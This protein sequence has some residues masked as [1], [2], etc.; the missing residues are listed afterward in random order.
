MS[1]RVFIQLHAS[2]NSLPTESR[3][4]LARLDI[5]W[6]HDQDLKHNKVRQPIEISGRSPRDQDREHRKPS[7]R[8]GRVGMGKQHRRSMHRKRPAPSR[9]RREGRSGGE[10]AGGRTGGAVGLV[11]LRR[12]CGRAGFARREGPGSLLPGCQPFA[13]DGDWEH[14][15]QGL[16]G[17][18]RRGAERQP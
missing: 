7:P 10:G 3:G 2:P 6:I 14:G 4:S 17:I 16:T 11:S 8:G 12:V 9:G 13:G 18:R 15:F 5:P 1:S